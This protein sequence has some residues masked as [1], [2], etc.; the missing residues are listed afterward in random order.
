MKRAD[1]QGRGTM[2][3]A[4][5]KKSEIKEEGGRERKV[6]EASGREEGRW[7]EK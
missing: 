2:E 3:G 6:E 5:S 1:G 4:E 7:K